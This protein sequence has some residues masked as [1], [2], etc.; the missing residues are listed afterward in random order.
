M[1]NAAVSLTNVDQP[2]LGHANRR[3]G[4]ICS[5]TDPA[6]QLCA[7]GGAPGLRSTSAPDWSFRWRKRALDVSLEVGAVGESVQVAAE[8]PLLEPGSSF[9]GEVVGGLSAERYRSLP[10]HQPTGGVD[11]GSQRQP[12][13]SRA[14]V[15]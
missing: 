3:R 11:A 8:T 5:G 10:G 15:Q 1:K 12:Q 4:R 9:L 13:L 7:D 14:Q 6:R 2:A